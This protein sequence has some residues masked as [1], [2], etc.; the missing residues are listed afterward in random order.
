MSPPLHSVI[1]PVYKGEATL[2]E[3]L[4]SIRMQECASLEVLAVDDHSPDRCREILESWRDRL[5]IKILTPETG[6][7]WMAATNLGLQ[8]ASGTWIHFLHQDD[9]WESGRLASLAAASARYPGVTCFCHNTL[10]LDSEGRKIGTWTLPKFGTPF[11]S[12]GQVLPRFVTQNPLAVP[13]VMFHHSLREAVGPLREDMW[14]LADWD[15]WLRIIHHAGSVVVIPETLAGFRIHAA[16]QTTTLSDR[17]EDLRRQFAEI[18]TRV[19]E[20]LGTHPC[21]KA[22]QVNEDLTVTLANWSHHQHGVPGNVLLGL[23]RLGPRGIHRFF[24]DTRILQRV[25]PRLRLR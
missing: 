4:E 14:F 15:F 5:E 20:L 1:L 6:G 8:H 17:E 22:A 18:R 21:E 24:Q 10:F 13:S 9:R 12:A 23:L 11:P 2:E 3:T 7:N 25:L 19:R 16:S